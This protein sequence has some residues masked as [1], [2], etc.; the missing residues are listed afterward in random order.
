VAIDCFEFGRV[1]FAMFEDK[2]LIWMFKNGHHDVLRGIYE[3]YKKDLVALAAALLIDVASA[4]GIGVDFVGII[5]LVRGNQISYQHIQGVL[6]QA[7][8]SDGP[9]RGPLRA[10]AVSE[11]RLVLL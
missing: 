5:P 1:T 2:L 4:E 6:R 9:G 11:T 7:S 3:R 10:L 8:G